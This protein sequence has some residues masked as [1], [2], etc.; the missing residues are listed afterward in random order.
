M[1]RAKEVLIAAP[2][3]DVL[4]GGLSQLGYRL[5]MAPLSSAGECPGMCQFRRSAP[6]PPR[7]LPL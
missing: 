5:R 4:L 6:A 3:H 7:V 1:R 2:V